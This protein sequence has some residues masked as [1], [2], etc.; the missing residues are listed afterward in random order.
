MRRFLA[1]SCVVIVLSGLVRAADPVEFSVGSFTFDRPEG[2]SWIVPASSMRKA[3]LGV[4]NPEGGD[5]GE[6][7]FFH[8][9][10]G[11]GGSVQDNVT[12]WIGQFQGAESKTREE[13]MGNTA[14]T[15]V[16]ATGTFSSGMPGG[17]TTPKEGYA[18]RGAILQSPQGGV[19]VKFTGPGP[20]VEAAAPAF[21]KMV[22]GAAG[23]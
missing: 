18:L 15:F 8:F 16:Q 17:P 22:A 19:Y 1:A 12:R 2:W 6:I 9:G 10:P 14:V 4:A 23:R 11:Q 21:E 20:V 5:A 13:K 7:T 3:Q